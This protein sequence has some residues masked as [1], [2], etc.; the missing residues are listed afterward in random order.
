MTDTIIFHQKQVI[1]SP[2]YAILGEE[3][4]KGRSNI[5]VVKALLEGGVRVIQYREKIKAMREKYEEC[6]AI[7]KL[8]KEA[9]ATFI[10]ND[11]LDLALAVKA[12]GIHVGQKDL[13]LPVVAKLSQE[14]L[15]FGVTVNTQEELAEALADGIAHYIGIGP[16]YETATKKDTSPLLKEEVKQMALRYESILPCVPIGGITET[17]IKEIKSCGFKRAAMISDLV[18][19]D[20]IVAK[21]RAIEMRWLTEE[22][23]AC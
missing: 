21:V 6:L 16:F 22:N 2:I 12:D 18:G 15:L 13:P 20:D 10:I 3:Q 7:R 14:K 19:A 9:K 5:E 11:S 8:T 1:D 17:R 4:G 23:D